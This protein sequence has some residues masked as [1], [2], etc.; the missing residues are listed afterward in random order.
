MPGSSLVVFWAGEAVG[1]VSEVETETFHLSGRWAPRDSPVV[2][3][4]L[5]CFETETSEVLVGLGGVAPKMR[6]CIYD[7]PG[8]FIEI[9]IIP[10]TL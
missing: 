5:R 1:E 3:D 6:G 9:N 4:F 10:G 8:E 2:R 7:A